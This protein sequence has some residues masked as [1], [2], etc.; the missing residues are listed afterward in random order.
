[1]KYFWEC[2]KFTLA[3]KRLLDVLR[4]KIRLIRNIEVYH[5]KLANA[6][7]IFIL[8][9]I[10]L[11]IP[12]LVFMARNVIWTFQLF[13]SSLES[14][15]KALKKQQDKQN[16]LIYKMLPRLVVEKLKSGEDVIETFESASLFFSSLV[17]FASIMRSLNPFEVPSDIEPLI[18]RFP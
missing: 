12:F 14:R 7:G 3:A 1:M 15:A 11:I 2:Q 17:G 10:L 4:V 6:W 9:L 16:K 13:A 8:I 18:L 5:V